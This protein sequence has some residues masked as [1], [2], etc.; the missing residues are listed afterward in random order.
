MGKWV[1]FRPDWT[2]RSNTEGDKLQQRP[3]WEQH[4][5][6][7]YGADM[8]RREREDALISASFTDI[9]RAVDTRS[10]G[11][12]IP[13][14]GSA[15]PDAERRNLDL[16]GQGAVMSQSPALT[17]Q[18]P[19]GHGDTSPLTSGLTTSFHP[20]SSMQLISRQAQITAQ[21]LE[22]SFA[23]LRSDEGSQHGE[24]HH[25]RYVHPPFAAPAWNAQ[26]NVGVLAFE[27]ATS[28][29]F[30]SAAESNISHLSGDEMEVCKAATPE[31]LG[32][33]STANVADG[34]K[35][36]LKRHADLIPAD[37]PN[38]KRL[39][40][41]GPILTQGR[42]R[43]VKIRG[44]SDRLEP[45]PRLS[46][47]EVFASDNEHAIADCSST[48]GT[49]NY[50]LSDDGRRLLEE[51]D[52]GYNAGSSSPPSDLEEVPRVETSTG[53]GWDTSGGDALHKHGY[54][55]RPRKR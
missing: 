32:H 11:Y 8:T 1:N 24:R 47:G 9:T 13:H 36:P 42:S 27:T 37:A 2:H 46:S 51:S 30:P 17:A 33:A 4:I 44:S 31:K 34:A 23:V 10:T 43:R 6:H 5:S 22:A 40:G 21:G 41:G 3:A 55:L 12:S 19:P 35:T 52:K 26:P 18:P 14:E 45:H 54:M 25:P 50:E 48:F 15:L 39:S 20:Q 28:N 7:I 49:D 16:R 53:K 29:V 38:P